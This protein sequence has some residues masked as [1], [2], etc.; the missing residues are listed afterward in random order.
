MGYEIGYDSRFDRFVGYGV[1]AHC[2]HPGCKR[3]IDRGLAYVC[4]QNLY[5]GDEGCG[6]HFCEKHLYKGRENNNF[7]CE[8]CIKKQKHFKLKPEHKDWIKHLLKDDS[9]K[10]WRDENPKKVLK[11]KRRLLK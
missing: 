11:Y 3:V 1:I 8:R 2:D 10:E 4:G 5:G 9:W 7:I 6:L